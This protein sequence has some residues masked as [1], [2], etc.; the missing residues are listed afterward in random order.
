MKNVFVRTDLIK[1]LTGEELSVVLALNKLCNDEKFGFDISSLEY[2][3]YN[4]ISNKQRLTDSLIQ[5]VKTL[6]DK[7]ILK[8]LNHLGTG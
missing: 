6:I 8:V 1:P 3:M 7:G 2:T 4:E 5:T